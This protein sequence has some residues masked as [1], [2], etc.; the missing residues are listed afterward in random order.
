MIAILP[1]TNTI[2]N[3]NNFWTNHR[4]KLTSLSRSW[5]ELYL[6]FLFLLLL[7]RWLY[8]Y[9]TYFIC[10]ARNYSVY[11]SFFFWNLCNSSWWFRRWSLLVDK[12]FSNCLAYFRICQF[13]FII[14]YGKRI[15]NCCSKKIVYIC[16][17]NRNETF[18]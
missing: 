6:L 12:M 3:K 14:I 17:R 16:K 9:S 1:H 10:T 2:I 5:V 18:M 15:M 7:R 13:L 11:F 4:F 8:S